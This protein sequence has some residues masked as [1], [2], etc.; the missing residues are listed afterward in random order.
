MTSSN[1]VN[2][3]WVDPSSRSANASTAARRRDE[4]AA[5]ASTAVVM[6]T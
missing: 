4:L 5:L 3:G 6:G 2:A 1:R